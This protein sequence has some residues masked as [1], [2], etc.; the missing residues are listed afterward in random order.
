[1]GKL[2]GTDGIR[3]IV[4]KS[5]NANLAL[6]VGASVAQVLKENLDKDR[7][8]FLIG[9]DTRISKDMFTTAVS[10]GVLG[11]GCNI[12]DVGVLP[13][14]AIAYL[15]KKYGYDGAFIISASHNP[16]EYNG[17]KVLDS[18]G[19][20][21]SESLENKCEELI[22]NNFSFGTSN[23]GG[24]YKKN[25]KGIDDYIDY[26]TNT[27]DGDLRGIK[28]YVDAANGAASKTAGTLFCLLGAGGQVINNEPDGYNINKESG[29]T[30]IETLRRKVVEEQYDV[31]IAYDGDADRCILVDELGNVIDGDYILAIAGLYLKSQGKL[32]NNTI[33]G[34]VM[35]NIG[36]KK[37]CLENNI[38]FV[39]TKVGD[40][41]V[42]EEMLKNGYV[43]GGEQS[44]H[45]IFKEHANTGD[46]QLTSIQILYIMRKTNKKLSELASVMTK[47]PQVLK[48]L[49]VTKEQKDEYENRDDIK[50]YIKQIEI[51]ELGNDGRILVRPSGTENL[52]RVMIE[53]KD[54]VMINNLCDRIIDYLKN[55]LGNPDKTYRLN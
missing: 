55:E 13:T 4:G 16:S 39:D 22:L 38:H 19:F 23:I 33:V 24:T 36:F 21:L 14:P 6:R 54:I 18:N 30:H 44:G 37:F 15:T 12:V 40:K 51:Q 50:E 1:M 2:F 41:Y 27:I 32:D 29:S 8:T 53:G 9:S 42:L 46:G 35:T 5:I 20:K 25:D 34:T 47:Y 11:E 17:I 7:L 43:L 49:D 28:V 10:A 45:I 52:I 26:L 48:N 31:G 3:G